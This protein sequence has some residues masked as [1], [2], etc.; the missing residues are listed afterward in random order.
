MEIRLRAGE[1]GDQAALASIDTVAVRDPGRV[2]AIGRWL[3][4]GSVT[5]AAMDGRPVGYAAV[6]REFFGRPQLG[7]LMVR[8]DLRGRA[9]GQRGSGKF[10]ATTN[11]S[12]L[13]MHRLLTR[14]GYRSCG[15]VEELDPGDPEI[16]YCKLLGG[17]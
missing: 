12:N 2:A 13:R 8:E 3:R 4:G 16:V 17:S 5:V 6:D 11:Q 9:I 7:M 14:N 15:F 1:E 10:F